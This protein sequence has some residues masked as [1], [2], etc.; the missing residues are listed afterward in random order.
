MS[1]FYDPF[2][3]RFV[4]FGDNIVITSKMFNPNPI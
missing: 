3:S 4:D 2:F 1:M